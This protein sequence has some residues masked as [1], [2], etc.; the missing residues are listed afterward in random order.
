MF[1]ATQD[2]VAATAY[3]SCCSGAP[4]EAGNCAAEAHIA[5]IIAHSFGVCNGFFVLAKAIRE[6]RLTTAVLTAGLRPVL[7]CQLSAVSCKY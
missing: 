3:I 6:T 2:F 7:F 1:Y 4:A 5:L